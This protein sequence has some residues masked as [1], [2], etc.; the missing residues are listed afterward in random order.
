[1]GKL[2]TSPPVLIMLFGYPGAGK[3]HFA[4]E[5]SKAMEAAHVQGDRIRSELFEQPQYTKQEDDIVAHLME[6]MAEEF[7]N[8]G[9]SV[10]FDTNATRLVQ[11][12]TLR[13]V[14]RKA[15][16]KSFIVWLQTDQDSAMARIAGRDRRRNDDKFARP[17]TKEA[18]KLIV[19]SMQKPQNEDYVVISGKHTFAMQ[20]NAIVKKLYDLGAISTNTAANSVAKPGLVNLVPTAGRVDPSRRNVIIR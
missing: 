4:S 14:A 6:Y 16:A 11:R 15:K 12:R 3:T 2:K 8:A 7:L 1:M 20:R 5:L 10:I 17:Y 18:F 9:V 19:G 13:D